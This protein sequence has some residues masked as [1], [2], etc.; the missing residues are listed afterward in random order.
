MLL[1]INSGM[2]DYSYFFT[3]TVL[4][5]RDRK[6]YGYVITPLQCTI[7]EM[8][9]THGAAV[10]TRSA[11]I[12]IPNISLRFYPGQGDYIM[13]SKVSTFYNI[14]SCVGGRHNMPPPPARRSLTF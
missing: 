4:P 5:S 1:A 14:T 8:L 7:V 13:A 10:L 11:S 9:V 6:V 12:P 3:N 2:L